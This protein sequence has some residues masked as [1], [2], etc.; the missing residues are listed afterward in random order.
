[1]FRLLSLSDD[2]YSLEKFGGEAANI[3]AFLAQ[4]GLDGLELMR[5]ENP[6]EDAVP[7]EKV[8]GRHMPYWPTFLDFWRGDEKELIR[9]FDTL[10]NCQ[11]YYYASSRDEFVRARH[12][13]LLDAAKMDA[14]YVVFHVSHSQLAHC[15]TGRHPYCD[16]EIIDAFI[17]FLNEIL[18]DVPVRY[19]VLFENHWLPGLTFLDK[20]AA[21]RLLE[22]VVYPNKGFVLDISHLMNTNR[23]LRDEKEA[24]DYILEKLESLGEAKRYIRTVH[25]NSSISGSK[26]I[27]GE[28]DAKADFMT[29]LIGAMRDVGGM[30][31]HKPFCE[32]GILRVLDSVRPEYLVYELAA[33]SLAELQAAVTA[34][35]EA[36]KRV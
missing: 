10:E 32:R 29:R 16:E 5:W 27:T 12:N 2:T 28:Y 20:E 7:M 25:L 17:E 1:M 23:G 24:V 21:M 18:K 35:N 14:K 36:L 8:V 15:Y 11:G 34:Q 13:E 6:Q 9:Q 31:P 3:R 33:T 4:N 26:K 19:E 30:D 22:R